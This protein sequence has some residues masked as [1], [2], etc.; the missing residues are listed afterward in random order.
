MAYIDIS[1]LPIRYYLGDS[2]ITSWSPTRTATTTTAVVVVVVVVVVLVVAT[3][4][5]IVEW[6]GHL[7]LSVH[8]QVQ[9]C[10]ILEQSRNDACTS[11]IQ[12]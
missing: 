3:M 6:K 9:V 12:G 1:A 10:V 5:T 2:P 11:L 8:V 4:G 7:S